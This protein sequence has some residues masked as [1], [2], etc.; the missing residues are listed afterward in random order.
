MTIYS[1]LHNRTVLITGGATGI[2]AAMVRAFHDQGA[3]VCFCD[4]NTKA[5]TKLARSLGAKVS[6]APVDLLV[7]R[8]VVRWI[9]A[10]ARQRERIDVLVNNAASDPRIALD[11]T[12]AAAWDRLFA[13]NLRAFF[14]ACR[15]AVP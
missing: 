9:K 13:R 2:G 6:F 15:E 7:E 8:Q 4:V 14:L 12:S 3:R 10:I 1:D 11:K 5:G